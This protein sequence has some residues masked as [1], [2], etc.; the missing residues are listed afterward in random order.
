MVTSEQES[1]SMSV[2]SWN[3]PLLPSKLFGNSFQH[4]IGSM[5]IGASKTGGRAGKKNKLLL[6]YNFSNKQK[7]HKQSK[8]NQLGRMSWRIAMLGT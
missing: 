1:E 7:K 2:E 5:R 4:D 8:I 6:L 3:L